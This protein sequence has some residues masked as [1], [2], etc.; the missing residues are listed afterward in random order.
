MKMHGISTLLSHLSKD[1]TQL[2]I[3]NGTLI[4]ISPT[5]VSPS[6]RNIIKECDSIV[7]SEYLNKDLPI[8]DTIFEPLKLPYE[9][10]IND[11]FREIRAHSNFGIDSELWSLFEIFCS[12]QSLTKKDA[13]CAIFR[14]MILRLTGQRDFAIGRHSDSDKA[15]APTLS[16]ILPIR[17]TLDRETT[18]NEAAHQERVAYQ[19]ALL[20]PQK[21]AKTNLQAA[22][23]FSAKL[24]NCNELY[25]NASY[26]LI[27]HI[28]PDTGNMGISFWEQQFSRELIDSYIEAFKTLFKSLIEQPDQSIDHALLTSVRASAKIANWAGEYRDYPRNLA[29]YKIF[30][31]QVEVTP[32]KTALICAQHQLSYKELNERANNLGYYLISNGVKQ[33]DLVLIGVDKSIAYIVAMLAIIKTGAVYVPLN[34]EYPQKRLDYIVKDTAAGCL[35]LKSSGLDRFKE[36]N[37]SIINYESFFDRGINES[38]PIGNLSRTVSAT[39]LSNIIYTSGSTGEP[40]GVCVTHRGVSRLVINTNY[41]TLVEGDRIAQLSN[42]SFDAST[43]EIWAALLNGSTLVIPPPDFSLGNITDFAS[44]NQVSVMF[45][46]TTLFASLVENTIDLFSQLRVVITGGDVLPHVAVEK[47]ITYNPALELINA[48]GPTENTGFTSYYPITTDSL[49]RTQSI[50]IGKPIANTSVYILDQHLDPV[51]V[52]I[53][54]EIYT[55]G[56]GVAQGYLNKPEISDKVFIEHTFNDGKKDRLYKT[57]DMGRFLPD[58]NIQFS[59]RLD[60]QLKIRGF[61]IEPGEIE[62]ALNELSQVKAS[63][64]LVHEDTLGNKRLV[65]YW[66]PASDEITQQHVIDAIKHQ[67]PEYML[68]SQYIRLQEMPININGKLDRAALLAL[69]DKEGQGNR[70]NIETDHIA[71]T[72]TEGILLEIWNDL[73]G[74]NTLGLHDDFFESGGDSIISIQLISRAKKQ[75]LA[76]AVEDIFQ[77]PTIAEL[78]SLIDSTSTE[79]S[80]N[81]TQKNDNKIVSGFVDKFGLHPIQQWFFDQQ[82]EQP[83]HWNQAVLVDLKDSLSPE[84]LKRAVESVFRYHDSLNLRF[85]KH[86][87]QWLQHYADPTQDFF[88]VI[89]L[90]AVA[91]EDVDVQ[92]LQTVDHIHNTLCY[93]RG[94]VI[95]VAVIILPPEKDNKLFLVA[96]H[97]VV[98]AVSWRIILED[99]TTACAALMKDSTPIFGEK[100]GS[101]KQWVELLHKQADDLDQDVIKYWQSVLDVPTQ[102]LPKDY[103]W[104]N[105]SEASTQSVAGSLSI[106]QTQFLMRH[107][108][109]AYGTDL[110]DLL[111]CAL[112]LVLN[113]SFSLDRVTVMVEGHGREQQRIGLDVSRTTGWFTSMYPVV[114]SADANQPLGNALKAIKEQLRNVPDKG[115]SFGIAR[116]GNRI[117]PAAHNETHD[118]ILF[119]YLGQLDNALQKNGPF[120]AISMQS[121][122]NH[123][124]VNQRTHTLDIIA[125]IHQDRFQ[126]SVGFSDGQYKPDTIKSLIQ[127]YL[128]TLIQII[129]HCSHSQRLAYTPSDFPLARVSQKELDSA[130]LNGISLP[131]LEQLYPLSPAQAGMLFHS[132]YSPDSETYMVQMSCDIEG[133]LHPEYFRQAWQALMDRHSILRSSIVYDQ[134]DL[135]HQRVH[136]SVAAPVEYVDVSHLTPDEQIDRLKSIKRELC[137]R[138][139]NLSCAPLMHLL[140]IKMGEQRHHFAWTYHHIILDGWSVPV[141][142]QALLKHYELLQS[143]MPLA[144]PRPDN[145]Q[146]YIR[147]LS[148]QNLTTTRSYWLDY[149]DGIETGTS[150]GLGRPWNEEERSYRS[151]H[152]TLLPQLCQALQEFSRTH[153][154]TPA[155]LLQLAWAQV[156]RVYSNSDDVMFGIT[157]SGRSPEIEDIEHKVGM[158]INTIPMRVKF[159]NNSN[160]LNQLALIKQQNREQTAYHWT[161]LVD[162]Q[163]WKQTDKQ[164]HFLESVLVYENYPGRYQVGNGG[165]HLKLTNIDSYE[166]NNFPLTI[167]VKQDEQLVLE[168]LYDASQFSTTAL[169]WVIS[170]FQQ[171]LG[172]IVQHPNT[173]AGLLNQ[174]HLAQIEQ[175]NPRTATYRHRD[176]PAQLSDCAAANA[177]K[178]ALVFEGRSL[179]YTELDQHTNRLANYLIASGVKPNDFVP[180][181]FER[182]LEMVI[183]ILAIVKAGGAYVPIEPDYPLARINYIVGDCNAKCI[184]SQQAFA[185][186]FSAEHIIVLDCG[187]NEAPWQSFSVQQPQLDLG[188]GNLAYM[189][190]T[191]GST[192]TPKGV[193]IAHGGLQNRIEWM[194]E[195]YGLHGQDVVLQKT[196]YGFDVSVWEFFWPLVTGAK[197]VLAKPDGHKDAQYL[198]QLI[199]AERVTTLHFVPSM[200]DVFLQSEVAENCSTLQRVFC[201]GEALVK[202]LELKFFKSLPKANLFN[203]YGPTEASI[204]VSHW[205]CNGD[206]EHSV[207]PIGRPINNIGLHILNQQQYMPFGAVGE[208]C[209]SGIGLAQGYRNLPDLTAEKFIDQPAIGVN[210]LYRTGDLARYLA[211]GNIEYLGR[212]DDQVK[213]R[214]LRI[215]PGE[216]VSQL[217]QLPVIRESAV[218][219]VDKQLAAYYVCEE[220]C[221]T[222]ADKLRAALRDRL[223]QY[224]LPHYFIKIDAL[225]LSKNGKLDRKALPPVQ[226]HISRERNYEA[227]RNAIEQSLADI[228]KQLLKLDDVGIHEN[229]FNLGGD[230]ILS[231]QLVSRAAKAGLQFNVRTVF[232]NPTIAELAVCSAS[233]CTN[234]FAE[235]GRVTGASAPIPIQHWFFEQNF[236]FPDYWNQTVLLDLHSSIDSTLLHSALTQIVNQ[237]DVLTSSFVREGTSYTQHF[238]LAQAPQLEHADLAKCDSSLL[239]AELT[240]LCEETQA[241]MCLSDGIVFKAVLVHT[242]DSQPNKLILSAHHLVVDVVSWRIILEDLHHSCEQLLAG[243]PVKLMAKTSAYKQW[244]KRIQQYSQKEIAVA[245]KQHWQ[246][247]DRLPGAIPVDFHQGNN[248]LASLEKIE[249]NLD[250]ELTRKLLR[251]SHQAYRTDANALL[252]TALAESVGRWCK[253]SEIKIDLE[254]HGREDIDEQ[255]DVSRTVGWFTTIY[256]VLLSACAGDWHIGIKTNKERLKSIPQRGFSYGSYRYSNAQPQLS[257]EKSQLIFNYLGQLDSTFQENSLFSFAEQNTGRDIHPDNHRAYLLEVNCWIKKGQLHV[258]FGYSNH[259]HKRT[260]IETLARDYLV[261]LAQL[262]EHCAMQTGPHYTPSDFP[263]AKLGQQVID[264][265]LLPV[266]ADNADNIEDI[267]PLTALQQGMLFH[268]LLDEQHEQYIQQTSCDIYGKLDLVNFEQAWQQAISQHSILRTAILQGALVEPLQ[269]VLKQVPCPITFIDNSK[270]EPLAQQASLSELKSSFRSKGVELSTAPLFSLGIVKLNPS[271]HHFVWTYHHLLLDGWSLPV[272]I[273]EVFDCYD[274]LCRGK[275]PVKKDIDNYR[276][277]MEFLAALPRQPSKDYWHQ[278]L[279]NLSDVCKLNL[280]P[281]NIEKAINHY[282]FNSHTL[283]LGADDSNEIIRFCRAYGLTANTIVRAA[284]A[285]LLARYNDSNQA[286]FGVT[287]SGRPPQLTNIETKAGLYIN[288]LPLA[289]TLEPARS[290]LSFMAELQDKQQTM[291]EHQWLSLVE[292][293]QQSPLDF[294]KDLFDTLLVYENYPNKIGGN[295]Q[296]QQISIENIHSVDR[297]NYPLT[298]IVNMDTSLGAEFVFDQN[299]FQPIHIARLAGHFKQLVMQ[300]VLH[301]SKPLQDL[302]LL[303]EAEINTQLVAWNTTDV[304]HYPLDT[305][306]HRFIEQQVARTPDAIALSFGNTDALEQLSYQSLNQKANQL[307]QRLIDEGIRKDCLIGL[308]CYRSLEMVIAML[309]ILKSGSAY[310]PLDPELPSARLQY[311]AEHSQLSLILT[312]RLLDAGL[313]WWQ[314]TK[315]HLD[316]G[317]SFANKPTDNLPITIPSSSLA[318]VL[319]T[320]GSTGRPKG[321]MVPH[322]GVVNR[323]LWMQDALQLKAGQVVLQKTPYSFDVSVWEFFWPLMVGAR[324][325]ICN[326]RAHKDPQ[327]LIETINAQ[328]VNILHFVPSM[329]EAWL[330]HDEAR[331]CR[332][333]EKIVCSGEALNKHLEL[334]T[335][336]KLDWVELYNLYGPTEA[337]IDVSVWKCDGAQADRSVPIGRPIANTQLYVLD[338]AQRLLPQ[339]A[340]G[341]LC[342]AGVGL[343]CG[344]LGQEDLTQQSFVTCLIGNQIRRIYRTA[345]LVRYREDG[346]LEY[347]GRRDHQVKIRGFR[348]ELGEIERVLGSIDGVEEAVAVAHSHPQGG[349]QYL[350]AYFVPTPGTQPDPAL[351]K[352]ALATQ[353]PDYMVPSHVIALDAIRLTAN[354]KVDRKSLPVPNATNQREA[355]ISL[356]DPFEIQLAGLWKLLLGINQ[357]LFANDDFFALGGHSLLATSLVINIKETF[358]ATLGIREI[359][360]QS[361]LAGQAALV[362]DRLNSQANINTLPYALPAITASGNTD[363]Q[364]PLSFSQQRLWFLDQALGDERNL[365]NMH[366]AIRMHAPDINALVNAINSLL[367]RHDILRTIFI[368]NG[369]HLYQQVQPFAAQDLQVRNCSHHDL[370]ATLR[371]KASS[372]FNLESGPLIYFE[373]L[374]LA[375]LDYVLLINMH[376]IISDGVTL[377]LIKNELLACYTQPDFGLALPKPALQYAD[378]ARWQQHMSDAVLATQMD[379]WKNKLRDIPTTIDLPKKHRTN[380]VTQRQGAYVNI[381]IPLVQNEQLAQL[382]RQQGA[383]LFMVL[384]GLLKIT[385]G[386]FSNQEDIVVGTPV[387][388]RNRAGIENMIGLFV[389]TL[390]LRSHINP[391]QNLRSV[392]DMVKD[393]CLQAYENQDIPFERLVDAL[394][395]NRHADQSP[396]FQVM[397]VLQQQKL[398]QDL[399]VHPQRPEEKWQVIDSEIVQAKFDITLEFAELIDGGLSGKLIYDASVFEA[400]TAETIANVFKS[401]ISQVARLPVTNALDHSVS[402]FGCSLLEQTVI[403][404]RVTR[405]L[406]QTRLEQQFALQVAQS[407]EQTALVYVDDD[408]GQTITLSYLQLQQRATQLARYLSIQ[409]IKVGDRVGICMAR[410]PE[411]VITQLAVLNLGATCVPFDPDYPLARKQYIITQSNPSCLIINNRVTLPESLTQIVV[412][413][414]AERADIDLQSAT[415]L[416][417]IPY[418]PH[419]PAYIMYTSGST[420]MP[421]GVM[422]PH[423][424]I[425]RLVIDNGFAN[426]NRH[427][428]FVHASNPSFDAIHLEIWGALL[429]GAKTLV[430][431]QEQLLDPKRYAALIREHRV[432][433]MFMTVGLFNEYAYLLG[434]SFKQLR[435]LMVGGEALNAKTILHVLTHYAP[436]H[437]LN[438]YGPTETTTFATSYDIGRMARVKLEQGENIPIGQPIRNTTVYLLNQYN[439]PAPDGATGE[440]CIGGAGVALGYYGQAE[441]STQSFVPHPTQNG[442][443]LYKSGDL[444][445]RNSEGEIEF[446]GRRDTQV[447][448]RGFRIELEE[449]RRHLLALDGIDDALVDV[450]EDETGKRLYAYVKT[451]PVYTFSKVSITAALKQ[452]LPEFMVPEH[453][454]FLSEFPLTGNGK[455]DHKRLPAIQLKQSRTHAYVAPTGERETLMAT[456]WQ[457]LLTLSAV[458]RHDS[459]FEVGGNSLLGVRLINAVRDTF[460]Q[461]IALRDLFQAPRLCDFTERLSGKA[462]LVSQPA[463]VRADRNQPIVL[464]YT[465]QRMWFLHHFEGGGDAS[466][467]I[468]IV[469][470]LRDVDFT[471]LSLAFEKVIARHEILRTTFREYQ[472]EVHQHIAETTGFTL[473]WE[474]LGQAA[475]NTVI[476]AEADHIFCLRSGPLMRAVFLDRGLEKGLDWGKNQPLLMIT[477]H[478]I[479]SDGVSVEVLLKELMDCCTAIA[480]G[481]SVSLPTDTF[482]YADYTQWERQC[483][484]R[485]AFA[486][487]FNY[488]LDKLRGAPEILEM[489]TDRIRPAVQSH[490][491]ALQVFN[492]PDDLSKQLT[493]L[494]HE[495]GTTTF[496][497]LLAV[498]QLVLSRYARQSDVL[499]GTPVANRS[500]T[501]FNRMLGCFVNTLVIRSQIDEQKSFVELLQQVKETCVDAFEH[502]ELPFGYLVEKMSVSR[503]PGYSPLFQVMFSLDPEDT[504]ENRKC[505]VLELPPEEHRIAKFDLSLA[506]RQRDGIINGAVEYNCDLFNADTIERFIESYLNLLTRVLKNPQCSLGLHPML[507]EL[508]TARL[509]ASAEPYDTVLE[510]GRCLHQLFEAQVEQQP[511]APALHFGNKRLTYRELNQQAN[512]VAHALVEQHGISVGDV[513]GLYVGRS[514]NMIV[515]ILAILKAGAA[516]LPLDASYPESRLLYM[517][518]DAQITTVI[519]EESLANSPLWQH[520]NVLLLENVVVPSASTHEQNLPSSQAF[521]MHSPAYIIYTSGSTGRPKGVLVEHHALISKFDAW[522]EVYELQAGQS[523][524]Q[525]AS[526]GFDVF[527][528]DLT[529]ALCSGGNLVIVPTDHLLDVEKLY[530]YAI[531]HQVHYADFLPAVM[532]LMVGYLQRNDLYLS[533]PFLVVGSD[534]WRGEDQN[535]VVSRL[536]PRSKLVNCY[537]VTE[538]GID[539]CYFISNA[540]GIINSASVPIGKRFKYVSL[541]VLDPWMNPCPQGMV[542]ELYIG[543]GGLARGY[544]G[545]PQKTN[546]KFI[547]DPFSDKGN[548]PS[549]RLYRTG[550]LVRMLTSGDL[551]FVGRMDDQVKIRGFRIEI[552]EIENAIKTC[553]QVTDAVVVIHKHSAAEDGNLVAYIKGTNVNTAALNTSLHTLLPKHMV[554]RYCVVLAQYPLTPN[555]KIDRKALAAQTIEFKQTSDYQAPQNQTQQILANIWSRML[556]MDSQHMSINDDF[557]ALGGHSILVVKMIAEIEANFGIKVDIKTAFKESTIAQI[558]RVIDSLIGL[559]NRMA[560][561]AFDEEESIEGEL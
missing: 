149:L 121:G 48:Y 268:S 495:Q 464:S 151:E 393:T 452:S 318:Y 120:N 313:D 386:R 31:Q 276:D 430:C 509:V 173:E 492:L 93:Q 347:I 82:F 40:K 326:P 515:G 518:E 544:L 34:L 455:V 92:V 212:I 423:S 517:A 205:Q 403:P 130:V 128:N 112:A 321:V 111:L 340:V 406:T 408:V 419:V 436:Q 5:P 242:H 137:Q 38:Y 139:F 502:Q 491:G 383:T 97:L 275:Q 26:E 192:G 490:R 72:P 370:S 185:E 440:I 36:F 500:R 414:S 391:L 303:S 301:S 219:Q 122:A 295:Q 392:L 90:S 175:Q 191:S 395:V 401:I 426:F 504:I 71:L 79:K 166:K 399:F 407:P 226:L 337:S 438:V 201:S 215:E 445:R 237:H 478:H 208:L 529:R 512:R 459:F 11:A 497:S 203:L 456:I 360:L 460:E 536:S 388:N 543:G 539:S 503:N 334:S 6:N 2:L 499:V 294:D 66:V 485:D 152:A 367:A 96:H 479:I 228:W 144:L 542:G 85:V 310:V 229:F 274:T 29:I 345:D 181:C 523:H 551:E 432:S 161:P 528:A 472:N 428:C 447:K 547:A 252:L 267:Y 324:L 412:N 317:E 298:V 20:Q 531:E 534:I 339:G 425:E 127:N 278:T 160:A 118:G 429:N 559:K 558:A 501:E 12:R 204:D 60:Q 162:I 418:Q 133:D 548:N 394:V 243:K 25:S 431:Q 53:Y 23:V 104:G 272:V 376:H 323:L 83:R 145:Y 282:S 240:R 24:N 320:S 254:G 390:V 316:D 209:I 88:E 89:D 156:L 109:Q 75:G 58:G 304:S 526:F 311:M 62:F 202:S 465:Q 44:Q 94:P 451:N 378:Y 220:G 18:F 343:A 244:A 362:R 15:I 454:E 263:L 470:A 466:Y 64:V 381:E 52:G 488:W 140:L 273:Q 373:L 251:Q 50:P 221:N 45:I 346:E 138:G 530:T 357:E 366:F 315:I 260:T 132:L 178:T 142:V 179:S 247:L 556:E 155:S 332:S 110:N 266:F 358:G 333:L 33:G 197:L 172:N 102:T 535:A 167:V 389:N 480:A 355:G 49:P 217:N 349:G 126:V 293:K 292:I 398:G 327:Y 169:R 143:G 368:D 213:I 190:Y 70:K 103:S 364:V 39:D 453:L 234:E 77:Y 471:T 41:L 141:L 235:Q 369:E 7:N 410:S 354:G 521:S 177:H 261:I 281:A 420:G 336:E 253:G 146:D 199:T 524:L 68:P 525:M 319:Y 328:Q 159:D 486:H 150:L 322:A 84:L 223:P 400:R 117:Q 225:P 193:M 427:D 416:P 387:A 494:N 22:L 560:S 136:H 286:V 477:L 483:F 113:N 330:K 351:I 329:L 505:E 546:E 116:L 43:F 522:R 540:S 554:P 409:G 51:P 67:L 59:G 507:D 87:N 363:A 305:V 314:G 545:D 95:R 125:S 245:D 194:Q 342:I 380:M 348:I 123:A 549:A 458:S 413:Y 80:T 21:Q 467:N 17:T 561:V 107:A 195:A 98:D 108:N 352:A 550:D 300:L 3:E 147:F 309:A 285:I 489:P 341:E 187:N 557:F 207:L 135:P 13:L 484:A 374:H 106:G 421:K 124:A 206:E 176:L 384:L 299:I 377:E 10:L 182:S 331:A 230:S 248:T 415:E 265:I 250:T 81:G 481:N 63:A 233:A 463:L 476:R 35:I 78:A 101:Y 269:C 541:Y 498:F 165:K 27:M 353:L 119:N 65:A 238:G 385:L 284:W 183:A 76:L 32:E 262:I 105:Y 306:L 308:H 506:M 61:R 216:I 443:Y 236:A 468:P 86:D 184:V 444:A 379:Y 446:L 154:F 55:G 312:T 493:R 249:L 375:Q 442:E 469:V 168:F 532:R 482:Q 211:D 520:M 259:A 338:S 513:V 359:F 448:I 227:P 14:C 163:G 422:V 527:I 134:L 224:M 257:V 434:E 371:E 170:C 264:E 417:T 16:H 232:K 296:Q 462:A 365:Y 157:V 397:F 91:A 180:I 475:L 553:G 356:S 255:L 171:A 473:R 9:F 439:Q 288:T 344:Y 4:F 325:H 435:Y 222:D 129:E 214:G 200:L 510:S 241:G 474:K 405:P 153:Q 335:L 73:L 37:G 283:I 449:V 291:D 30:E 411:H 487:P 198:S 533:I 256:P 280:P 350:A 441:L 302:S 277:F 164:E 372:K 297:T 100:T 457:D 361:E 1:N 210:R 537:G 99:I 246:D 271:H 290:C 186:K 538:A 19:N 8:S 148:R 56:D 174:A 279:A 54:G 258:S 196:P 519:S 396:L 46:T 28:N 511:D 461:D 552:G 437:L 424:G 42:L 131:Q 57:G 433:V 450:A 382:G 402:E 514:P 231:I 287:V 47:V 114:L 496:M 508:Q 189:I 188:A 218:I 69:T 307:A 74:N 270:L 555:G 239:D 516:Y 289:V 404:A 115:I 158:Y